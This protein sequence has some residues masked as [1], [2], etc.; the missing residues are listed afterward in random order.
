VAKLFYVIGGR[1]PDTTFIIIR[2][3]LMYFRAFCIILSEMKLLQ[4]ITRTKYMK[5]RKKPICVE[6]IEW[7]GANVDEL[8]QFMGNKSYSLTDGQLY[9][10]TM[11][12]TL[13]VGKGDYIIRGIKGEYYPCKPD[14]FLE[15]Y[16]P[17]DSDEL[18]AEQTSQ[19]TSIPVVPL[20]III[21]A[22]E[23]ASDEWNQYLDIEKMAV[24]SLPE[25]PFKDEY[26]EDDQELADLIDEEWN[27]RFF[28]LPD[29]YE[30][31]EYS[32]MEKFI[33]NLTNERVQE[34]LAAAIR[35][36]GAFRRFKDRLY[37]YGLEK[38]W[39]QFQEQEYRRIAVEWC[40]DHGFRYSE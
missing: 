19:N 10:E 1:K 30:I 9:I 24:V 3:V 34:G 35:G 22:I 7:T 23:M 27:T 37:D 36:R 40:E 17:V 13:R 18:N 16:E 29:R 38:A 28:S 2:K 5:Y 8:D 4:K 33:R 21:D 25:Y 32:I 12:G 14:V 39:Y 11:E 15:T 6:A 20:N 26:D 31:H